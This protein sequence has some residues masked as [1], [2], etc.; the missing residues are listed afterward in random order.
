MGVVEGIMFAVTVLTAMIKVA[1]FVVDKFFPESDAVKVIDVA[2]IL[3]GAA[4][5]VTDILQS[6]EVDA[7]GEESS[8]S[9]EGAVEA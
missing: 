4:D 5:E 2:E 1:D 3:V 9:V 7:T 6:D 8:N